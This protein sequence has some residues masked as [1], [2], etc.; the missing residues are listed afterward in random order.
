M[1]SLTSEILLLTLLCHLHLSLGI[2]NGN[3]A[4]SKI[5]WKWQYIQIHVFSASWSIVLLVDIYHYPLERRL[6][7]LIRI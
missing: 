5:I 7:K 6:K 3:F 1:A 4:N 2:P